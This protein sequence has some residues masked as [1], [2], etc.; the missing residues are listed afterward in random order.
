[1]DHSR[2]VIIA[3][4]V[5]DGTI[6]ID[7]VWQTYESEIRSTSNVSTE[8]E[9]LALTGLYYQYGA[10]LERDGYLKDAREIYKDGYRV[11]EGE[12]TKISQ[13]QYEHAIETYLYSLARINRPLNDYKNALHYL[14]Q[15]KELFPRKDEYREAYYGCLSSVIAKYTTPIY[16]IIAVLF[17]L[18]MG[19]IYI[20]KTHYIPGWLVDAGWVIWVAM[21]IVQFGLPWFMKKFKK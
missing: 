2:I 8:R 13:P 15:L 1:M 3:D 16:I 6:G 11:L 20:F 19:E 7:Q 9:A 17:L 10:F 5:L 4:S 18:K 14:K 12:K 21:L